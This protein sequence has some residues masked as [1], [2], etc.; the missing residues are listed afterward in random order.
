MFWPDFFPKTSKSAVKGRVTTSFT[1]KCPP[2]HLVLVN[3]S[4]FVVGKITDVYCLI[5]IVLI[6]HHLHWG[7]VL[8]NEISLPI[9][10]PVLGEHFSN[11][12]ADVC[13]FRLKTRTKESL[14]PRQR[15]SDI[16]GPV[17]SKGTV[18]NQSVHSLKIAAV[19]CIPSRASNCWTLQK[20]A[21]F[22]STNSF[23]F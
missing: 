19:V 16:F 20:F 18:E 10:K 8:E 13:S 3:S 23:L 21:N 2:D 4:L 7:Q 22:Q 15:P 14:T 6:N 5:L 12:T 9:M 11:F 1:L 17:H